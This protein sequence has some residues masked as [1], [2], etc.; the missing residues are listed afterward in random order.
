MKMSHKIIALFCSATLL[1]M[2]GVVLSFLTFKQIQDAAAVRKHTYT[3][4]D[5]AEVLLSELRDAE[6]GQRGY[7]LTGDPAFLQP[8]LKVRD[9]ILP[10]LQTL[11]A[12][13][14]VAAAQQHLAIIAPLVDA[15]LL[16]MSSVLALQG[17]HE[18]SAALA[19]VRNGSGKQLMDSIRA[20]MHSFIDI[21]QAVLAQREEDFQ[22]SMRKL[23]SLIVGASLMTLF[24]A[25][26]FA[27]FLYRET[28]QRVKNIVHLETRHLLAEQQQISQQ[29]QDINVTLQLSENRLAVTLNSIGDAVIATDIAARVTLLN[30]IAEKLTGWTQAEAAGRLIDEIF[31]IINKET[32]LP[33]PIPIVASLAYGTIQGLANHTVLTSRDGSEYDIAD[34]CAPIRDSTESVVG[35]VLVFRDVTAEYRVQQALRDNTSLIQAI[36]NTVVDGIITLRARGATITTVN[37]SAEMLF[38]YSSTELM[39]QNF[40]LLIPELDQDQRN[41]S[42]EYYQASDTARASGVGREVLGKRKDG[43]YFP[44]EIAMSEMWLGKERYFTGILRDISTR[45]EVEAALIKADA[46]Q[47][48]IFTSANF[49]SIATDAKGVI[50]IFNVGAERMLGYAAADVVNRVTPAEISDPIELIARATEL[51]VA[52]KTSISA[53]FEALVFKASRGIEDIYDLTYIRKDGSRLPAVVSVTALR[54][55]Q[56]NIIGYLLIGTD[57]TARKQ[58]EAERVQLYEELQNKN[59][60]L[61]RTTTL[62]ENTNHAKSTFLSRMSHELRTPLNAILG[63]AQLLESG[64]PPPTDKQTERLH[65]ITKAGWYLLELINE[66]L[67]LAV[68]ESG[69]LSLSHEP[70]ALLEVMQECQAMI[71]SQAL[72]HGIQVHFLPFDVSWHAYADRTRVKQVLANLLTNAVKYNREQGTVEV[73]CSLSTPQRI[74]VSI[75][76]SGTGLSAQQLQQLF[77]PFNRLGQENGGEEGTGIGLVVTKQLIELMGG[78]IG[79]DST[80][81]VGSE[82]WFEL[83]RDVTPQSCTGTGTG[84]GT[85]IDAALHTLLYVEDNPANLMLVE[86]IISRHAKFRMLSARDGKLGIAMALEHLPDIILMDINLPGIN[87]TQAMQILGEYPR[88][89]HIPVLALSANAMPRDIE[90]GLQ[91]GFFRYLTKPIKLDE[92]LIALDEAVKLS[93]TDSPNKIKP[94]ATP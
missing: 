71:E 87:G 49:S 55:T 25:L 1:L 15:K 70:V 37:P 94:G 72:Q 93:A 38:G 75:K 59:T 14:L 19:M 63:F 50:Q 92:F 42:L 88:T 23:F 6:T 79:V 7:L 48:A 60:E 16:E 36:L 47:N 82:F 31:P 83:I 4:L 3:I 13:T 51:T 17:D 56:T 11:R 77:Q 89:R 10:H 21:E 74:R 26:A 46:L 81:G 78:T 34:S 41:G 73:T 54:D 33:V 86:Q 52:L 65:H 44:M 80:V 76:D 12:I 32:R 24:S 20:E 61:A 27:Y 90:N 18:R 29:L 91:A 8:Y 40:S 68:I 39:G 85:G 58:V 66:I 53:G 64:T 57:N 45:K 69:K 43:S 62:A 35:A 30:P 5:G 22:S 67:D 84:T 9:N 2:L 28:H